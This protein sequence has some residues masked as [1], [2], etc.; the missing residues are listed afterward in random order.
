ME[1]M[2]VKVARVI[3]HVPTDELNPQGRAVLPELTAALVA[4]YSFVKYPVKFEDYDEQKGVSYELGKWNDVAIHR[5]AIY[6]TGLLCDTSSST[7]DSEAILRDALI[8]ASETFG[9]V[10]RPDMFN[11]KVYLSELIV[12][13]DRPLSALNP[14]LNGMT[15]KLSTR[16]SEI[17]GQPTTFEVV[18]L[19][20]NQDQFFSKNTLAGFRIERLTDIPFSENRYYTAASLPTDEHIELLTEFAEALV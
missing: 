15:A 2:A 13:E 1:V 16:I 14:K 10:Y 8:W 20:M 17:I 5:L 3:V 4:R 11:R 6:G 9:L 12:K 7:N 18:S 19:G